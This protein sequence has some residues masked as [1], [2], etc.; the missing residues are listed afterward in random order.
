MTTFSSDVAY[1]YLLRRVYCVYT[2]YQELDTY[3]R[4]LETDRKTLASSVRLLAK[5]TSVQ[6]PPL[7]TP[8]HGMPTVRFF[9]CVYVARSF[10][11]HCC[12]FALMMLRQVGTRYRV[13]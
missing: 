1:L 10:I 3:T 7:G 2:V 4:T 6:T 13:I 12:V 9:S 11:G 8:S 5:V